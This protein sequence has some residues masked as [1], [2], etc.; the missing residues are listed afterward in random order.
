MKRDCARLLGVILLVALSIAGQAWAGNPPPDP[1]LRLETGEHGAVVTRLSVGDG[2]RMLATASL[3][4]TIRLWRLPGGEPVATL[5]VPLGTGLEGALYGVAL[6]PDGKTVLATGYTGASWDD[7][8]S[9]YVFDVNTRSIRTRLAKLPAIVNHVAFSP[10]GRVFAAA[11]GNG[12]G[13]A[14]WESNTG[15]LVFEDHQY[16]GGVPHLAFDHD[17]RL[18]TVC[19]NGV[20]RLYSRDFHPLATTAGISGGRPHS[21]AFSRDGRQIAIGY[22]DVGVVDVLSGTDLH[23]VRT[24]RGE[25]LDGGNFAAVAWDVDPQGRSQVVAGGLARDSRGRMVLR[26]WP[27]GNSP[28]TDVAVARDAI[29]DLLPSEDGILFASAAPSWGRISGDRLNLEHA[30]GIADFRDAPLGRFA[31]S[32]DGLVVE[33]GLRQGGETPVRFDLRDLSLNPTPQPDVALSPPATAIQS[34]RIDGW[35]NSYD[36]AINGRR[37]TLLPHEIMRASAVVPNQNRIIAGTNQ[38]LV[39]YDGDGAEIARVQTSAEVWAVVPSGDGRVVVAALGDGTLRWFSLTQGRELQPLASLFPYADGRKWLAWTHEGF[40]A[41]SRG[42][43]AGMAGYAMN[44]GKRIAP[45]WFD[46]SRLYQ[47]YYAPELL[48][49]KVRGTGEADIARRVAETG[50]MVMALSSHPPPQ[51]GALE[52]CPLDTGAQA[53]P[54]QTAVSPVVL[55]PGV[56]RA[57]LQVTVTDRQGGIGDVDLFVNGRLAGSWL[58]QGSSA[59]QVTL[60]K[61]VTFTASSN[62]V[63]VRAYDKANALNLSTTPIEFRTVAAAGKDRPEPEAPP[64]LLIMAVSIDKYPPP[65]DLDFP[66][67][68]TREVVEALLRNKPPVYQ[69]VSVVANLY[70][71]YATRANVLSAFGQLA[72]AAQSGDSV[73]IYLSGHGVVDTDAPAHP[74]YFYVVDSDLYKLPQTALSQGDLKRA[75]G[76]IPARNVMLFLDTCNS[77]NLSFSTLDKVHEDFG[78]SF[79]ILGATSAGQAE[80]DSYKGINGPFAYAVKEGLNSAGKA[81]RDALTQVELAQYVISRVPQL[82]QEEQAGL[83]QNA[84]FEHPRGPEATFDI[85]AKN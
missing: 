41:H 57:R 6:S 26:R 9:L 83:V 15:R 66:V 11:F 63:H 37:L 85:A 76:A 14:A 40:F 28:P 30:A 74:Y 69:Q 47:L 20:V 25:G 59:R 68:D 33:F 23:L 10:D 22:E 61:D 65:K 12:N 56:T 73:V 31:L 17:G 8:F 62:T 44:R 16:G 36:P 49:G 51:I 54:C 77:G 43:E 45:E 34:I 82:V 81:Q 2:G 19:D 42:D 78:R 67:K 46:F 7:S 84:V 39:E 38:R 71:E 5:R 24:L 53:A 72:S 4:K 55:P 48:L 79:D 80:I 58:P 52:Y 27:A 18:A 3:D 29:M 13:V 64:R 1:I 21:V 70:D 50:S 60:A 75:L 35:K 32:R